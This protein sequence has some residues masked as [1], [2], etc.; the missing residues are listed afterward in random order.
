[1]QT[2]IIWLQPLALSGFTPM[3][4]NPLIDVCLVRHSYNKVARNLMRSRQRSWIH[5]HLGRPQPLDGLDVRHPL[6]RLRD[7]L[8]SE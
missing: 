3:K 8:E 6:D 2:S 7:A 5:S 4:R 1:M